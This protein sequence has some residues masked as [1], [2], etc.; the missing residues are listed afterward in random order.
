MPYL[1]DTDSAS[2]ALSG[3]ERMRNRIQQASDVGLSSIA[4]E[5][6]TRGALNL[7]QQNRDKPAAVFAHDF[8]SRL[9]LF[10]C[11][12]R[13]HTYDRQAAQVYASFSAQVRR[14]GTQD[15]RIGASAIAAGLVVVTA[16]R[17]DFSRIPGVVFEDWSL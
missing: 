2:L 12:C 16:N 3:S 13:I 11:D 5:E 17:K 15:C 14:V 9:L 6:M 8:L 1:L 7:I 10:L 4:E